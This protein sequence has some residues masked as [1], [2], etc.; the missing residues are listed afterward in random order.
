MPPKKGGVCDKCGGK[1]FQRG[2]DQEKTI[3]N[4]LKVYKRKTAPLINFYK[5]R[6]LLKKVNANNTLDIAFKDIINALKK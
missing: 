2:D 1:L 5:K 3:K 6:G 4:R